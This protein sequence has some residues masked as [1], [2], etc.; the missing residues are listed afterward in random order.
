MKK[1]VFTLSLVLVL[2][3]V[4]TSFGVT[5]ANQSNSNE[6]TIGNQVWMTRNLN[7]DKFRNGDPIPEAKTALEWKSAGENGEPAW[8]YYENDPSNGEQYGK[9]YNWYAVNDPRGLAPEGW[10]IPSDTEWM[11]T[12][13]HQG[14]EEKAGEFLKAMNGWFENGNGTNESGFNALPSGVRSNHGNFSAFEKNGFWWSSTE[15][16][17]R[18]KEVVWSY[19]LDY[20]F[21]WV[22]REVSLKENGLS[23]R[24]VKD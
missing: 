14:G 22:I 21:D 23:V 11:E 3:I 20:Y 17:K 12:I 10:H 19:Y 6:V 16:E 8:C 2:A 13:N 18:D 5:I 7:V 4:V 1:G 15:T 9:I 24:C